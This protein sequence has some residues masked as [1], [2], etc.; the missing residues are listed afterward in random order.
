MSLGPYFKDKIEI[1][2]TENH[3]NT[4]FSLTQNLLQPNVHSS[5]VFNSFFY[6]AISLCNTIPVTVKNC[7]L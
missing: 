3:Y 7:I 6:N 4:N 1:C 2:S 5:K